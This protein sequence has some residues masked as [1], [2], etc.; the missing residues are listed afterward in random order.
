MKALDHRRVAMM[1]RLASFGVLYEKAFAR[2]SGG[3]RLFQRLEQILAVIADERLSQLSG[4]TRAQGGKALR[5]HARADLLARLAAIRATTRLL[6]KQRRDVWNTFRRLRR[7]RDEELLA[8]ARSIAADVAPNERAFIDHNMP[9]TFLADLR[10]AIERFDGVLTGRVEAR[11][12]HMTARTNIRETMSAAAALV[13]Q[14]DAVVLNALGG[15]EIAMLAWR[16][17]RRIPKPRGRP[18]TRRTPGPES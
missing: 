1:R 8:L 2:G 15:D 16:H 17:S 3:A 5:V 4:R 14:L 11:T 12:Q 13:E 10:T 9:A 18:K 7:P 6:A